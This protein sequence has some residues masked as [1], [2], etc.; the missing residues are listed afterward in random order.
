MKEILL[1]QDRLSSLNDQEKCRDSFMEYIRYIWPQFIEGDHHRVVA[2]CL[3]RVASGELKRLIVN[4][5]PRH[6]KSEFAS[7]Y[8]PSW[9]MGLTPDTK[10]MQTTHTS[11]LSV[12]FGRKV[13]NLM[14]SEEYMKAVSYTHL[15]LPTIYSV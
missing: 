7:V 8:F 5:P 4:M 11:E 1:L 3:D 12:R 6:T 10:I 13:R 15:T 14:D 9:I 2:E